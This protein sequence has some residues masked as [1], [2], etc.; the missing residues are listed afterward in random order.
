[1]VLDAG[2]QI[3]QPLL[4]VAPALMNAPA[5]QHPETQVAGLPLQ[6]SPVG[7]FAFTPSVLV[8]AVV[9]VPGWQLS[10]GSLPLGAPEA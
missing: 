4:V 7:Q 5:I 6:T 10:H 3:W 1:V 9:L 2:E 8:Q